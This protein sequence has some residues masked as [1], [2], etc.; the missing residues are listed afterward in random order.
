MSLPAKRINPRL[1]KPPRPNPILKQHIQLRITPA[2][3][4]RKSEPHPDQAHKIRTGPEERRERTPVPRCGRKLV[5]GEDIDGDASDVGAHA[6]HDDGFGLEE[7]GGE[8]GDEG[9]ADGADGGVVDE[10]EEEDDAADGPLKGGVVLTDA[11]EADDEDEREEEG[12]TGDVE[13]TTP[14][15]GHEDPG[16]EAG[17]DADGV[18]AHGECEGGFVA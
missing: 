4:L 18:D 15:A 12:L 11:E 10:G 1:R 13:G 8:F 17:D 16:E 9:V 6:C 2:P 14:E 3:R 7:G 5:V